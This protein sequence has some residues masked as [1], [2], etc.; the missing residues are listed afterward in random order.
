MLHLGVT[1][2]VAKGNRTVISAYY[3]NW[4]H[5]V[6]ILKVS[7]AQPLEFSCS[8]ICTHFLVISSSPVTLNG[9]CVPTA[10]YFTSPVLVGINDV[11]HI[12]D[13]SLSR[14]TE[15]L[16]VFTPLRLTVAMN[17]LWPRKCEWKLWAT[18]RWKHFIAGVRLPSSFLP[19][20]TAIDQ[21]VEPLL[22]WIVEWKWMKQSPTR[23]K[24]TFVLLI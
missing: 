12:S 21:G 7:R 13:S 20:A 17:L 4:G 6:W 14:N 11:T 15:E 16:Y 22:I 8:Y 24:S 10:F 2:Y 5:G 23:K 1:N 19:L 3:I 18:S 9:I